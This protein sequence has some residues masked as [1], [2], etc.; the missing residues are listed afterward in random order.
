M[1]TCDVCEKQTTNMRTCN[2]C[3]RYDEIYERIQDVSLIRKRLA[4]MMRFLR[5]LEKGRA[6]GSIDQ[7]KTEIRVLRWVLN[8]EQ[9][10]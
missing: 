2:V 10:A 7:T 8:N 5:D 4:Y 1:N 3:L 6:M 9:Q